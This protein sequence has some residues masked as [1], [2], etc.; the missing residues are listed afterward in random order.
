[1]LFVFQSSQVSYHSI[2]EFQQVDCGGGAAKTP[3]FSENSPKIP[4]PSKK[5]FIIR[6]Q[7]P[8][9]EMPVKYFL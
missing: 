3:S 1:L 8:H 2:I 7:I 9:K 5:I 6:N 4:V